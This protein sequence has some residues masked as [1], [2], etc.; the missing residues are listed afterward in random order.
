MLMYYA[1]MYYA[2]HVMSPVPTLAM[3]EKRPLDEKY[4]LLFFP[5][6][7]TLQAQR[8]EDQRS[9]ANTSHLASHSP[10]CPPPPLDMAMACGML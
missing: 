5:L 3:S 4:K 2:L 6:Q 8:Q 10:L 9:L 1:V 7:G